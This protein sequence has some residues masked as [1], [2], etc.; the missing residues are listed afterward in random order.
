[1]ST[2]TTNGA[3]KQR[4]PRPKPARSIRILE[5]PSPDTDGW[6]AVAITVGKQ[7]DTYLLHTIP[8]D[9]GTG[10]LAFE[11]EK[12][13]ADLAT[14]ETYHVLLNGPESSCDCKGHER[15]GHCKHKDGIQAA[16]NTGRLQFRSAGDLAANDP[17][18]YAEHEAAIAGVFTP[19][20]KD[21]PEPDP[22]A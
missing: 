3:P 18:G 12:L 9:F 14:V 13:D 17:D 7:T 16:V 19:N 6:A 21:C 10:A 11:V 22:A 15:W 5:Q 4:K 2:A 8:T 1:M 20:P